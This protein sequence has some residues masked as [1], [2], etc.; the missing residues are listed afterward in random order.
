MQSARL[1]KKRKNSDSED[2]KQDKIAVR[3]KK[4]FKRFRHDLKQVVIRGKCASGLQYILETD[5]NPSLYT[6]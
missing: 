6:Y 5:N 2:G 4:S 3:K 1:T